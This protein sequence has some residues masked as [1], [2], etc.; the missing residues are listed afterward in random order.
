MGQA[1]LVNYTMTKGALIQMT[2]SL[3]MEFIK[4]DLRV[5]AIAPGGTMTR[6]AEQ[7]QA[8]D[9]LDTELVMRYVGYRGMADADEI[10]T[11]FAYLASDEA[12]GVHGAVF[13]IDRGTTTG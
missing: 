10:A 5:N 2:K 13:S 6:L 11:L 4:T 12:K 8:P 3:A 7:F 1:Y 9:D